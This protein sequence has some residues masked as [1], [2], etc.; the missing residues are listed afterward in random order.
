MAD[1]TA[2]EFDALEAIRVRPRAQRRIS[3]YIIRELLDDGLIEPNYLPCGCVLE[4][5]LTH[6]GCAALKS[7]APDA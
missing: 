1:L 4:Y 5:E 6:A 7:G 2:A 3:G